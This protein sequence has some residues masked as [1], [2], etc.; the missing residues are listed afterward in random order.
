M[1]E[2]RFEL[3]EWDTEFFQSR[4]YKYLLVEPN[5]ENYF[6]LANSFYADLIYLFTTIKLEIADKPNLFLADQKVTYHKKKLIRSSSLDFSKIEP[7][8]EVNNKLISLALVSGKYSRFRKDPKLGHKFEDLYTKWVTKSINGEIANAVFVYKEKEEILGFITVKVVGDIA[9][10]GLIATDERFQG[11]G[12]GTI[13][14][15][16]V[17]VW[18]SDQ[19]VK[20]LYVATQAN[21]I[22]AC[23]FYEKNGFLIYNID[24]I[25]HHHLT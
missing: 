2:N 17:E 23:K 16:Y 24:Y 6:L 4:I 10:I 20:E 11:K 13:L 8:K 1:G 18:C 22:L 25:Y 5:L 3:L 15:S 12:I 9:T 21:N 14:V 7:V 19:N